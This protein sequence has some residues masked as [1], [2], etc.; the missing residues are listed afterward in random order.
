MTAEATALAGASSTSQWHAIDWQVAQRHV[1]RLQM[2]I[3]KATREQR[4][5]KVKA[6][7]YLL[8][9][10]FYAKALAIKHVTQL[11]GVLCTAQA[12]QGRPR[13][14][15]GVALKGENGTRWLGH[16]KMA[17]VMA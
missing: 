5:G 8:T 2:R 15:T 14:R 9:R 11:S 13:L 4:Y 17:F 3:A 16:P 6:L 12:A 1:R 10:S 7:Q